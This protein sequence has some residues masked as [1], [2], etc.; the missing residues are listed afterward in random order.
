MKYHFCALGGQAIDHQGTDIDPRDPEAMVIYDLVQALSQIDRYPIDNAAIKASE[1]KPGPVC[2]LVGTRGNS[3][4]RGFIEWVGPVG[5]QL[6]AVLIG[7]GGIGPGGIGR[8]VKRLHRRRKRVFGGELAFDAI[9]VHGGCAHIE[10][11]I[12][13]VRDGEDGG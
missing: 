9:G 6:D 5:H 2:K 4:H 11:C 3:D 8:Q 1:L 7:C 12:T 13:T 10:C